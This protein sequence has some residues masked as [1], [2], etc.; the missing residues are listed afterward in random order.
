M[1]SVRNPNTVDLAAALPRKAV[2]IDM[3]YQWTRRFLSNPHIS[4]KD[5]M[6]PYAREVLEKL[7]HQGKILI[8]M[9]DQSKVPSGHEAL[10][11]SVRLR[12]SAVPLMWRVLKTEGEI[13]YDVQ[14][15]H[16]D[17]IKSFVPFGAKV[18]LM[19]DRFYGTANLI[20]YCTQQGWD[21]RL[22]LKNNLLV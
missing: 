10:M 5:I 16:L 3:R 4:P 6:Q 11:I 13:K 17:V 21:Y 1:L 14:K 19:G 8:V 2:P 22:R 20:S 15:E 12:D 7:S 9:M 18:V